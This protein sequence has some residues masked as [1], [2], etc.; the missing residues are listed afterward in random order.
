M[1]LSFA[2]SLTAFIILFILAVFWEIKDNSRLVKRKNI[3]EISNDNEKIKEYEFYGTF[4]YYNN[5]QWRM[6]FVSSTFAVLIIYI[7]FCNQLKNISWTFYMY[8][9]LIIF[10]VFYL[11]NHF[12]TFHTYRV[13]ANKVKKN[14]IIIL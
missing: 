3:Y 13:M 11:S 5:I 9:F 14:D 1:Q 7:A 4:N 10:L 2:L 6:I 8:V 12:K